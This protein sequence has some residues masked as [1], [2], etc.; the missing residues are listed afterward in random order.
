[1]NDAAATTD[2][3][4]VI[5]LP[6]PCKICWV[7]VAVETTLAKHAD[8]YNTL[9][10]GDGT[11]ATISFDS[12]ATDG[13]DVAFTADTVRSETPNLT[14]AGFNADEDIHF[15][16][17]HTGTPANAMGYIHFTVLIQAE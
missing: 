4:Q 6:F 10:V 15:K 2:Y 9:T 17:T 7:G 13:D 1:M 14:Y 12:H 5:N 16:K 3:D 8:N 11:N